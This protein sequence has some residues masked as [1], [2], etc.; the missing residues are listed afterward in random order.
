MSDDQSKLLRHE[1]VALSN[2][3]LVAKERVWM[4][5]A[6]EA[7]EY[8]AEQFSETVSESSVRNIKQSIKVM[9]SYLE[10]N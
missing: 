7:M 3:I 4:A 5:D 9:E 8:D 2:I 1:K 6:L 10:K